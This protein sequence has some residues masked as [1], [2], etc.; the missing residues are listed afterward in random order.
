[1]K[2][3]VD[4]AD[5]AFKQ[6]SDIPW[7]GINSDNEYVGDCYR[8]YTDLQYEFRSLLLRKNIDI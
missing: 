4:N 5:M 7:L 2:E 6:H 3:C 8:F 1:M